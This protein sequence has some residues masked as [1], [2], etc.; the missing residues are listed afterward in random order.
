MTKGEYC[1][2]KGLHTSFPAFVPNEELDEDFKNIV[3]LLTDFSQ[4]NDN[5]N[6]EDSTI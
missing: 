5:N 2:L 6:E 4:D 1:I 3:D